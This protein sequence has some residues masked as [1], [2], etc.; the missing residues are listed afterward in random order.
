MDHCMIVF[1]LIVI[2]LVFV[3]MRGRPASLTSKSKVYLCTHF[4]VDER[5]R[6]ALHEYNMRVGSAEL[7]RQLTDPKATCKY[8]LM[9]EHEDKQVCIWY[10]ESP[11]DIMRVLK[12]F[13]EYYRET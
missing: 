10:A 6:R 1:T 13:S 5:A 3:L 4:F 12:P 9:M 11:T 7:A 8:T 2:A